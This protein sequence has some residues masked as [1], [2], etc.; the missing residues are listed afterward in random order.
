MPRSGA[1]GGR[2]RWGFGAGGLDGDERERVE[3]QVSK[4]VRA[5]LRG[6]V[7]SGH[8]V[9]TFLQPTNG[10]AGGDLPSVTEHLA[11]RSVSG[12]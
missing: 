7:R 6:T 10:A 8:V 4:R 2:V 1:Y 3:S 11:A 9:P 5:G 12:G